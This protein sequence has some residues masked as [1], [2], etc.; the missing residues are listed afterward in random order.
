[1]GTFP[2]A[3][4]TEKIFKLTPSGNLQVWATGLTT[5]LGLEVDSQGRLYVLESM[6]A[7][8]NPGPPELGTGMIVR[9]EHSGAKTAIASG[10]SFPTGMTF[11]PDCAL[12]VSNLG[13]AGPGAGQILKVTV[14]GGCSREDDGDD[15]DQGQDHGQ[16]QGHH[17]GH[18]AENGS[19]HHD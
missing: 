10:L 15:D 9:I 3:P 6:T 16:G 18:G 8:G 7:P 12:Y 1:L 5:V 13:F 4:G 11:G 17:N 19:K 2:I 14:P